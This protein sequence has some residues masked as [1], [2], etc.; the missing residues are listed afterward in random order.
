MR[1]ADVLAETAVLPA[2]QGKTKES[3]L[4]ELAHHMAAAYSG[5]DALRLEEVLWDRERLGSTALGGGIAIPHGRL[6]E[7]SA[8]LAGFGRHVEG[9]DFQSLD[10]QPSHLFFVLLAPEDSVGLHLK[11]LARVSRLLKDDAFRDR[12]RSAPDQAAL[13]RLICEEDERY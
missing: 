13:Y 8:V 3:V 12:L 4:K 7:L 9:V 10:G 11:A 1:I 2:L 6:S 5:L